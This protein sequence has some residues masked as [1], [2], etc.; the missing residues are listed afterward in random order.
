[1]YIHNLNIFL[2]MFLKRLQ[3]VKQS[4]KEKINNPIKLTVTYLGHTIQYNTN[5]QEWNNLKFNPIIDRISKM[6]NMLLLR[7][8]SISGTVL[9]SKAEGIL[10]FEY[11]ITLKSTFKIKC[12]IKYDLRKYSQGICLI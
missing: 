5:E 8:L 12:L 1:M 10:R 9:L 2:K 4:Q 6:L 7:H 11:W 3:R